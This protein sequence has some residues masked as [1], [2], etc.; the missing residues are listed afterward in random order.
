MVGILSSSFGKQHG[1][2]ANHLPPRYLYMV[3]HD[4]VPIM[5]SI[6]IK[7]KIRI[8]QTMIMRIRNLIMMTILMMMMTSPKHL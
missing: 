6:M 4:F 5:T 7:M 1:V 2:F 3:M 8:P